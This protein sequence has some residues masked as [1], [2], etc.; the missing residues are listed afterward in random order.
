MHIAKKGLRVLGIAESYYGRER[1]T[2]A[3][4]VMRKDMVIDGIGFANATVGGMDA[5]EAIMSIFSMLSRKDINCIMLSGCIISWFN[6]IDPEK[7]LEETGLPVIGVS[8]EDSEGLEADIIHHFPGDQK[9]L[10]AYK[11][12]GMRKSV[13]IRTGYRI[14]VRSWGMAFN[15]ASR[16]CSDFTKDGKV[17]EPLRVARLIAKSSM[18][19]YA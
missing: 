3:G 10:N 8:Y 9:R 18:E 16:L 4:V 6:V 19:Y 5:T 7:I 15:D 17:P 2:L 12:L 1:S 14:F 13:D 11:K